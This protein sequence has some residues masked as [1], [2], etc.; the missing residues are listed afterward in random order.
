MTDELQVP[1]DFQVAI[2][3]IFSRYKKLYSAPKLGITSL[4]AP[5]SWVGLAGIYH[6]ECLEEGVSSED[7]VVYGEYVA[8]SSAYATFPPTPRGFA[9]EIKKLK[10]A[11]VIKET[12]PG[13]FAEFYSW[14]ESRYPGRWGATSSK[15]LVLKE[16]VAFLRGYSKD[17]FEMEKAVSIVRNSMDFQRYPPNFAQAE[18]VLLLAS[19]SDEIPH[20]SEAYHLATST[21]EPSRLPS[22]IRYARHK[23]GSYSLRIRSDAMVR[24]EFSD[25]YEGIVDAYLKGKITLNQGADQESDESQARVDPVLEKKKAISLVTGM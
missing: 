7:V 14:L 12:I 11:Q 24:R 2:K 1:R 10:E 6:A 4:D 3:P 13:C 25:F 5:H 22:I 15:L 21:T 9:C 17:A 20:P 19:S 16:W 8:S 18:K 23:F